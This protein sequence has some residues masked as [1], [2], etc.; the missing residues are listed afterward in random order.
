MV[1]RGYLVLAKRV[2]TALLARTQ[3]RPYFADRRAGTSL[4]IPHDGF[5]IH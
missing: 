1:P 4:D 5:W 2:R 3:V